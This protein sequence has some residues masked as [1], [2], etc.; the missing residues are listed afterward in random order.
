[1]ENLEY[2]T[3]DIVMASTLICFGAKFKNIELFEQQGTFVLDGVTDNLIDNWNWRNLRPDPT[4]F[5]QTTKWLS[6]SVRELIA[7][8][9]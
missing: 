6:K 9:G 2:K 4:R 5:Y 8:R 3:T 1:M 7:N